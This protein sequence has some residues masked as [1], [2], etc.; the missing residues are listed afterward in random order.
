MVIVAVAL[1]QLHVAY[2]A[3]LA[4]IPASKW[5][6]ESLDD[7]VNE[8]EVELEPKRW[9]GPM[10]EWEKYKEAGVAWFLLRW[11]TARNIV[12]RFCLIII[13]VNLILGFIYA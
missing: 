11:L 7:H 13:V 8:R 3:V 10:G 6:V 5:L 4:I 2:L 12:T 9:M 1:G